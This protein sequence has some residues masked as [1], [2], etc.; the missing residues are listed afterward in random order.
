MR[1]RSKYMK[2]FVRIDGGLIDKEDIVT[3]NAQ[4]KNS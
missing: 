1:N 2:C 4:S 3:L